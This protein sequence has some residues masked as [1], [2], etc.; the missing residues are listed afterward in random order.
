MVTQECWRVMVNN[1]SRKLTPLITYF[2]SQCFSDG[3]CLVGQLC[4]LFHRLLVFS[5]LLLAASQ[6]SCRKTL[7][8]SLSYPVRLGPLFVCP[9]VW[10]LLATPLISHSP[11][12]MP[13]TPHRSFGRASHKSDQSTHG[14]LGTPQQNRSLVYR[15]WKL[16]HLNFLRYA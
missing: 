11:A 6:W 10:A 7:F 4:L 3:Q 12:L 1:V 16:Q 14:M 9:F 13:P 5:P 15:N 2:G 8:A